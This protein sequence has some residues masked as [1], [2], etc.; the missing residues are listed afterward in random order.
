MRVQVRVAEALESGLWEPSGG[1]I[2]AKRR[3]RRDRTEPDVMRKGKGGAGPGP[4]T[5]R[6]VMETEM[7]PSLL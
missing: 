3:G 4:T 5:G 1:Q 2:W 7:L 6:T